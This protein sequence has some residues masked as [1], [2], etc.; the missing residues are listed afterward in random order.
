MIG[1]ISSY[2]LV[3][4]TPVTTLGSLAEKPSEIHSPRFYPNGT[5][6]SLPSG[7]MHYWLFGDEN[8]RRVVLIHG[9]SSGAPCYD[10][11]ARELVIMR[12][13]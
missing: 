2:L 12:T 9:I 10:K 8:G 6:L 11:L 7:T 3:A 4:N 5:F 13:H 1:L